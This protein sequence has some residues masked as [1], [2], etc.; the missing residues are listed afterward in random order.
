[1]NKFLT[2]CAACALTTCASTHCMFSCCFPQ[3]QVYDLHTSWG[4]YMNSS[5]NKQIANLII[6]EHGNKLRT[7]S[8]QKKREQ[9]KQHV[10]AYITNYTQQLDPQLFNQNTRQTIEGVMKSNSSTISLN[11]LSRLPER[12][13]AAPMPKK[14]CSCLIL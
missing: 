12:P 3:P 11:I 5:K 8:E 10:D 1:M 4:N 6:K 14:S 7:L 2:V 13:T 9:T